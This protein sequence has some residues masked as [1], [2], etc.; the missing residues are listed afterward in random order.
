MGRTKGESPGS[1]NQVAEDEPEV[2]ARDEFDNDFCRDVLVKSCS[3]LGTYR[4]AFTGCG[5]VA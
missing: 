5:F 2:S 3:R 1:R 4:W